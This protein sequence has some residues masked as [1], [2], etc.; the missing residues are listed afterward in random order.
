MIFG[1]VYPPQLCKVRRRFGM[2]FSSE[3]GTSCEC[4]RWIFYDLPLQ[5]VVLSIEGHVE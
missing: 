5:M 1:L 2:V 3:V 4:C